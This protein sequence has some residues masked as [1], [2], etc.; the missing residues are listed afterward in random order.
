MPT[1][2]FTE[3]L[4]SSLK[5]S[6][7]THITSLWSN[8]GHIYRLTFPSHPPLILKL[9]QPPPTP[10]TA[11]ESHIRKLLSYRAERHFY[12]HLSHHLTPHSP[13]A[14]PHPISAAYTDAALLIDDLTKT[15]PLSPS[16]R[17][18]PAHTSAV[19]RWLANFHAAYWG[20]GEAAELELIPPPLQ[21][22]APDEA[23]GVWQRG[24]Y[25]YLDTRAEEMQCL[26]DDDG[27]GGY[28]FLLPHVQ[29]VAE[30]LRV[31][32]GDLGAT[33]MHGDCK[34]ANIVFA[35]PGGDGEVRCAL[36]DFQYVGVGLGVQDLAY[37]LGTSVDVRLLEGGGEDALLRGY[38]DELVAAL[39]RRGVEVGGY[40]WEVLVGQW[41]WAL[42]DWMRFMAGWGCW[43]NSRWVEGR[44][45]R[46]CERW[47]REGME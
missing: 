32:P 25:W 2:N 20:W 33:L 39:G 41:E 4:P 34:G 24:G 44:A 17:Y 12:T 13:I 46:I 9:I 30:R 18:S 36:Y 11:S 8:Y 43:G 3:I 35:P 27:D 26:L 16:H 45:R 5:P 7:H 23:R 22:A 21:A 19:I 47:V 37:F 6:S 40:T 1:P 28:A 38:Y 10:R 31:R 15:F 42:V 14:T 29:A